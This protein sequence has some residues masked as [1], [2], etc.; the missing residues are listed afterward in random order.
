VNT[1]LPLA[2]GL[3]SVQDLP[4]PLWL[5]YY[6]AAVVLVVSFVALGALWKRPLL[7]PRADGRPLGP[8]AQSIL[9]GPEIRILLGGISLALFVL[10]F[11]A[12]AI[13]DRSPAANITPTFVYVVFW[14]GLV[15]IVVLLG[16]VWRVLSPWRAAADAVAWLAARLRIARPAPF[17]YPAGLGRV[18]A[19]I[20]LMAFA[21]LELAWPDSANPRHLA[22]AIGVYSAFTWLGMLLFGRR[23]W[24]ENGEGFHVYFEL[25]SR[26]GAFGVR[27]GRVIVRMPLSAL[28]RRDDV[29]GTVFF[30]AVMLGSVAFDGFSRTPWWQDRVLAIE[31]RW[32]LESPT[33]SDTAVFLLNLL[34]LI[35]A[36]AL[37]A[38]VYLVAVEAARV[39]GSVP[40][41][42]APEF[43]GSLVPIALAYAVAHYFSS[44]IVQGQV[45]FRLASDPF[46][47]G[48]DLFG[49]ADQQPR[50]DILSPNTTWYV[51]VAALV[52][53]HVAGLAIAHDRAVALFGEARRALRTQ[54]AMLVLMVAYTVGGLYLL[55]A[56]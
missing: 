29:P 55:S 25:L 23:A 32:A 14:L 54:Y 37:V 20:G 26:I 44:L 10:L 49:T 36:V 52:I 7:E 46:G 35:A 19:G 15:P 41:T 48:W 30:V 6:G 1:A 31:T 8:R 13:G 42:L 16:N 51:Q 27:D 47:Y 18:P 22:I 9:L 11:L 39:V 12:A 3:G 17:T 24:L 53:G 38:L 40:Y 28:S 5:F 33:I 21:A 50:L 2:H 34:G 56:G 45:I 4:V 43:V